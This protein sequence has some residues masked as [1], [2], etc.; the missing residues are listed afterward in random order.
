MT[1]GD[2]FR[3]LI[4]AYVTGILDAS[5]R[6]DLEAHLREC[7][8]CR[9]E[10]AFIAPLPAILR[11]VPPPSQQSGPAPIT[12][13]TTTAS[14]A[15]LEQTLLSALARRAIRRQR[16][17]MATIVGGAAAA[18]AAVALV[19]ALVIPL[20][21]SHGRVM[22]LHGPVASG[23]A[24]LQAKAWGTQVVLTVDRLPRGA[25]LESAVYGPGGESTIGSWSAPPNGHA[26]VDLATSWKPA[27]IRRLVV[28]RSGT[29]RM[30]LHS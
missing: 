16:V 12:P 8:A 17:V 14:R 7:E 19:I 9:Q 6:A 20:R 13:G 26:V 27:A 3:T 28:F 23:S 4:G 25:V 24:V 22:T 21:P 2:R 15:P 5:E 29:A 10:L 30:I 11:R 1:E 18:A